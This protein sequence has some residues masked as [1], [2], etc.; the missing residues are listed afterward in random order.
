M[1]SNVQWSGLFDQS[2]STSKLSNIKHAK[3]VTNILTIQL[4][5]LTSAHVQSQFLV[6]DGKRI[7]V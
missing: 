4:S 7:G 2:Y 1:I 5:A 3:G 6:Q